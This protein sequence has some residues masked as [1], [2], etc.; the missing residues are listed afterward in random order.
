M[1]LFIS[2]DLVMLRTIYRHLFFLLLLFPV[3]QLSI[4]AQNLTGIWRGYFI[5]NAGEKYKLEFQINGSSPNFSSGV[6]YSYLDVRFYGKATMTGSFT[7]DNKNLKIREIKT[8][9]I[10]NMDG[11]G[12]CIM[13]YDLFYEKSGKEEF[14]EGTFLGKPEVKGRPN[15]YSWGDC[16][17]GKVYLRRVT[18][19]DFY[20]EPFLRGKIKT[21]PV[22]INQ[23]PIKKDT[24]KSKPTTPPVKKPV[25]NTKPVE[26]KPIVKNNPPIV[27]KPKTDTAVTKINPP[28]IVK[29]N[30]PVIVP[31]PAVLKNRTNEL[32]KSLIVTNRDIIV[33]LYDN[34]EID[35]DTISVYLDNKLM[36]SSKRLSAAPL[37]I[38][39]T[40]DEDDSDHELI[41][42]AENLGRIPPNTSLMVVEAGEQRFEVRI[43]STEQKNAV[44]RFRYRK[45]D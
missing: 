20:I 4:H 25:V 42:V 40:I 13:N 7:R 28:P 43:T 2:F 27:N 18:T 30:P 36:L 16:G 39:F 31:K 3:T 24:V 21:T 8:V 33:K 37:T 34:G 45:P 1:N 32:M 14:L 9:E 17:G 15:P 38:K 12:A 23:P 11:G 26:N 10:K 19:S 41:M 29:T 5:T 22:I 6:S 44:V 35:D